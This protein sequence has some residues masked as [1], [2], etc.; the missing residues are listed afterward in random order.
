LGLKLEVT[1]VEDDVGNDE[2][3]V[4]DSEDEDLSEEEPVGLQCGGVD[5]RTV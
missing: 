5:K 4:A 3:G 2:K 1:V